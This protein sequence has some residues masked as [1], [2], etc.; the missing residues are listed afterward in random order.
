[1]DMVNNRVHLEMATET[2]VMTIIM[3]G[4]ISSKE[5]IQVGVSTYKMKMNLMGA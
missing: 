3:K 2:P 5:L 1:M 4:L